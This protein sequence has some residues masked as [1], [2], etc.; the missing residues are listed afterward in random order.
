[1]DIAGEEEDHDPYAIYDVV[2][3]TILTHDPIAPNIQN[4]YSYLKVF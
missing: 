4:Q 1:M 3:N 2:C